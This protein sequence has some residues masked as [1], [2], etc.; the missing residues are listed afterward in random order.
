MFLL[1]FFKRYKLV[2]LITSFLF[3]APFF[4]LKPG[5]MTLGGDDNLLFFYDP[6]TFLKSSVIYDVSAIGRGTITPHYYN[7]TYVTLLVFLKHLIPSSTI[8]ISIFN[9]IKLAGGFVAIFLI[10]YEFTKGKDSGKNNISIAAGIIS[11][12]FYTVSLAS[13]NTTIFWA[14]TLTTHNQIFLNPIIFYLIFKFLLT[15]SYRYLCVALLMSFIYAPNFSL[16]SAPAFFAFYPLAFLFLFFYI[17][18]VKKKSIP[19]KKVFVGI[20]LFLGIQS[21]H[22]VGQVVNLLDRGS[23]LNTT[24]FN[25]EEI[26]QA[27]VNYFAAVSGYGKASLN[28]LL[29]SENEFLKWLSFLGPSIVTVG[30]LLNRRKKEFLIISIFFIIT[31]FLVTANI[32][33]IWLQLYKKLFYIPG[34]TMFRNF[35]TQWIWVFIFFYSLLFGFASYSILGKLKPYYRKI[36]FIFVFVVMITTSIPLISGDIILKTIVRGSNNVKTTFVMDPQY[37]KTLQFIRSLPDDGKILALP[38]TDYSY[39]VLYGKNG[40]AYEG[41][42]TLAVLTRKYSFV[43]YQDF[44]H[45]GSYP[46]AEDIMKYSREKNYDRLLRIFNTMNIRYIFHNS[47]PKAYEKSFF[48]EPFGYMQTSMPKTQDEYKNFIQQFPFRQIYRNGPYFIYE[49]DKS[50]YNSTIFIPQGVYKSNQLSFDQDKA[51]AVFIDGSTC[52]KAELK[53]LCKDEYKPSPANINFRMINPT[54]YSVNIRQND[55]VESILLVMQH[56][57]HN[58][59]KVV[60]DEKYIAEDA[61]FPVN[62]YANGWL[63]TKKDLPDKQ[64]YTLFIKLDPQKYFWYGLSISVISLFIMFVLLI[65]SFIK[66]VLS[67]LFKSIR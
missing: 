22:L 9:G 58:G 67:F 5:E 38:L 66:R 50:V 15:H 55:P 41:T 65:S 4:W 48:A 34:F 39:Q 24:I 51:H 12:I 30:F 52:S 57:F 56:T 42:S 62:G 32:T 44:G 63:L 47:D 64:V 26:E 59:W 8:I 61:H 28:L 35:Y 6:S 37:E 25:K 53:K 11:G 46:Y 13:F 60:S 14:R 3:I 10:I 2:F 40:G 17:K 29:P 21:F 49:I 19:W 31:F 43:G 18:I 23:I 36:F 54:L 20:L 27:G 33:E 45:K 1:T 16:T 7:F